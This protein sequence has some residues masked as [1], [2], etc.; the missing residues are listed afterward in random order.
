MAPSDL[1]TCDAT[2]QML[3]KARQDN[4]T[5]A[6][7][8][9][10]NMKACPIGADSACCKHCFMGPCRLNPKD[11]YKKVGIC[12]AT[13]DTIMARNFGRMVASGCASHNDH[14][15]HILK[16][17]REVVEGK[18]L[19]FGIK[20]VLKLEALATS[21]GIDVQD[22]T[23]EEVGKDLCDELEKNLYRHRWRNAFDPAGPGGDLEYLEKARGCAKG[24]HAGGHGDDEPD[25]YWMRPGVREP[26]QTDYKDGAGR[27][28]GRFHGGHRAV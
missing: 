1:T 26:D 16:L 7:D 12:G 22:R 5:I 25:P 3:E 10:Q 21:L 13:I 14:G 6:L 19:D 18:V 24:G 23:I 20:D 15:L 28:V 11:P 17:F 9:G 27:R 4:V 8:R 2:A